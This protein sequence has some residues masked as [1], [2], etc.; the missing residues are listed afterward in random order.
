[1]PLF[2]PRSKRECSLLSIWIVFLWRLVRYG[3]RSITWRHGLFLAGATLFIGS[4][5]IPINPALLTWMET[6]GLFMIMAHVL[7]HLVAF[8]KRPDPE[9][10]IPPSSGS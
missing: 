7:S 9:A 5:L 3:I 6:V 1:M 4:K 10:E 2:L 8:G